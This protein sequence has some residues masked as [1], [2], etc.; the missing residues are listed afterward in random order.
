MLPSI[1]NQLGSDSLKSL[2]KLAEA[3]PNLWMER[4]HL[5]TERMVMMKFQIL[6]RILVKL[7]RMKQ[8]ELS[9]LLKMIKLEEVTGSCYFIL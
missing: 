7:P 6:R 8:T 4:H 1:L 3:L 2:R 9:Q 5:L